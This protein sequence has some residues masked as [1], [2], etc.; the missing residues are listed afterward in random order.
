MVLGRGGG[1]MVRHEKRLDK[2]R[3]MEI[4]WSRRRENPV[5]LTNKLWMSGSN[6][7]QPD[8]II[9]PVL[10]ETIN[11]IN[12]QWWSVGNMFFGEQRIYNY[13]KKSGNDLKSKAFILWGH[14][15]SSLELLKNISNMLTYIHPLPVLPFVF[16]SAVLS[17]YR[18]HTRY[19]ALDQ[20]T[21]QCKAII[22]FCVQFLFNQ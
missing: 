19:K 5:H 21:E 11:W 12:L 6:S 4:S 9:R 3:Q 22:G 15:S 16:S 17:L 14:Y 10:I 7:P 2:S 20:T 13:T 1:C 18:P 8:R